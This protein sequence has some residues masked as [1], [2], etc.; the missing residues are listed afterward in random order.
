MSLLEA[1]WLFL[2]FGLT[3]QSRQI[4]GDA[5][6]IQGTR[7]FGTLMDRWQLSCGRERARAAGQINHGAKTR[8]AATS[9]SFAQPIRSLGKVQQQAA[10]AGRAGGGGGVINGLGQ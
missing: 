7:I 8:G 5:G 1:I 6:G 10:A 2:R 4:T 9:L 3:N